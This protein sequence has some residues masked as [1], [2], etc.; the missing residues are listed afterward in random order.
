LVIITVTLHTSVG[1]VDIISHLHT[2]RMEVSNDSIITD[3]KQNAM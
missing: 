1:F 2:A 3:N